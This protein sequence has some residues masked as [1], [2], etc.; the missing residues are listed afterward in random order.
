MTPHKQQNYLHFNVC[1][2]QFKY[3]AHRMRVNVLSYD[4]VSM[5]ADIYFNSKFHW[6]HFENDK[7]FEEYLLSPKTI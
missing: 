7:K 1:Q 5:S 6:Q 4:D 3:L 2:G